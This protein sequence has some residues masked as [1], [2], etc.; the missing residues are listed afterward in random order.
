MSIARGAL[1]IALV[2]VAAVS[3]GRAKTPTETLCIVS[4]QPDTAGNIRIYLNGRLLA[5]VRPT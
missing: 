1:I 2:L 4:A 3:V 5:T